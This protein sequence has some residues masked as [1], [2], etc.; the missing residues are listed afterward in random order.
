MY[1]CVEYAPPVLLRSRNNISTLQII[2]NK[3]LRIIL[4]VPYRTSTTELHDRKAIETIATRINK[5]NNNY[6]RNCDLY[7]NQLIKKLD[8]QIL[9]EANNTIA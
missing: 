7:N 6:W 3:A 1:V 2:Q 9:R 5:L 8:C 4:K